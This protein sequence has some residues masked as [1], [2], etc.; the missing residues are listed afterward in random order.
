MMDKN[1]CRNSRWKMSEKDGSGG[2]GNGGTDLSLLFA[3]RDER[4]RVR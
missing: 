3:V 2:G 1:K 4:D